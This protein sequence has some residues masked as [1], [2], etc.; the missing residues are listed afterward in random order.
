MRRNVDSEGTGS[1]SGTA[2]G[3]APPASGAGFCVLPR[4]TASFYTRP[5]VAVLPAPD[6]ADNQISLVWNFSHETALV[7]DFSDV[8]Y[9]LRPLG[10]K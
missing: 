10:A 2:D 6:L 4:S 1:T 9:L 7:Q 3:G 5:D 8:C